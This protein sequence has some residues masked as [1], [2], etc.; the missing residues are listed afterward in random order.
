MEFLNSNA[1]SKWDEKVAVIQHKV[2]P[3]LFLISLLFYTTSQEKQQIFKCV[4][5]SYFV[6]H[7]TNFLL[8]CNTCNKA[9]LQST[10]DMLQ[11]KG[12]TR[13]CAGTH[14]IS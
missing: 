14:G 13:S 12:A 3:V 1:L 7:K 8:F 5:V 11:T 2:I 6:A 10:W 4:C 9:V